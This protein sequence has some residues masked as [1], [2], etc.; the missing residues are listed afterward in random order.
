MPENGRRVAVLTCRIRDAGRIGHHTGNIH[1]HCI[2]HCRHDA[3][4]SLV[5]PIDNSALRAEIDLQR[6]W[7]ERNR[8]NAGIRRVEK[9]AHFRLAKS[10]DG[11]HRVAD[12]EQRSPV[13][14]GP[15]TRQ[16]SQQLELR[17]RRI[18][19]LIDQQMAD[20]IVQCQ[21]KIGRGVIVA[22]RTR[23]GLRN[24]REIALALCTKGIPQLCGCVRQQAHDGT[25]HRPLA[26]AIVRRRQLAQLSQCGAQRFTFPACLR[27]AVEQV[28]H[29]GFPAI[30]PR[31]F[32]AIR[33]GGKPAILVEAAA[34]SPSAVLRQQQVGN[35][36]PMRQRHR[37]CGGETCCVIKQFDLPNPATGA[38]LR[39][40][41]PGKPRQC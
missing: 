32:S 7:F 10:I 20:A 33:T 1:F 18:L 4:E 39:P 27:E 23:C 40:V 6:Q 28:A 19:K 22:Q 30:Q 2:A 15:A 24:F 14:L 16:L 3:T 17:N 9:Q 35:G 11:L 8:A 21:R 36:K 12:R 26:V 25:Q 13:A 34:L 29:P 37:I 5:H 38:A 41:S 31:L